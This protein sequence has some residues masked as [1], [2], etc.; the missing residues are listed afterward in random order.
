MQPKRYQHFNREKPTGELMAGAVMYGWY[1]F[2]LV[3]ERI[4]LEEG[5]K[6]N[7]SLSEETVKVLEY[8]LILRFQ[9]DNYQHL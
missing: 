1:N 3:S 6:L 2:I 7:R 8:I 5:I 4:I 9:K